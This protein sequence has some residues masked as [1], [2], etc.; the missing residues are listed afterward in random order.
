[1]LF[2]TRIYQTMTEAPA[3]RS[4]ANGL[5]ATVWSLHGNMDYCMRLHALRDQAHPRGPKVSYSWTSPNSKTSR[6]GRRFFAGFSRPEVGSWLP[7]DS[8]NR[9][10]QQIRVQQ[11]EMECVYLDSVTPQQT[12]IV[13]TDK[14]VVYFIYMP[15]ISHLGYQTGKSDVMLGAVK[16]WSWSSVSFAITSTARRA[17]NLY[18]EPQLVYTNFLKR[19]NPTL[20]YAPVVSTNQVLTA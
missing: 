2:G 19:D 17:Q 6:L 9:S 10:I 13:N 1:M 12:Y 16:N 20:M 3:H 18:I 15:V 7:H 4:E 14:G 8:L 5:T 11:V